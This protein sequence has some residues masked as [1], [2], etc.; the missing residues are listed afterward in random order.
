MLLQERYG[1]I[2]KT[3]RKNSRSSRKL[4]FPDSGVFASWVLGLY[5]VWNN[6]IKEFP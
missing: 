3:S 4:V 6:K 2:W 1:D 5:D